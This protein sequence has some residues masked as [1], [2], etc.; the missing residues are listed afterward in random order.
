[1]ATPSRRGSARRRTTGCRSRRARSTPRSIAWRS[2]A[3][4]TPSGECPRTTAAPSTTSSPPRA[5]SSSAPSPRSGQSTPR[6][7]SKCWAPSS[8]RPHIATMPRIP[9]LRRV[10]H[11]DRGGRAVDRAVDDELQFHFD[12]TMRDLMSRG[13]NEDDARA[14]ATRRFGDV[15]AT[16]ERLAT[17][18][19]A[20]AGHERR[21]EWW[22]AFAQDLRYAI[23]G[24]RLKPGFA[25]AV[26]LTLGLG[27][28]ANATMFQVVD[29]LL[30][31]PPAYLATPD[32]VGRLYFYT[33]YRGTENANSYTGYRPYLD[34][35]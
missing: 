6:P 33:S 14:E 15:G 32:R 22:S 3:G 35:R 34:V 19:R 25:I 17:I 21:A 2:A 16:R 8:R 24:L 26:I 20:R 18:D 23:R 5:G 12:M 7:S 30:F 28:G 13:M 27:I 29:R 9:G 31:R 1:M 4:S 11:V 10:F